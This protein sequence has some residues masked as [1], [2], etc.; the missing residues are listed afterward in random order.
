[1]LETF[2]NNKWRLMLPKHRHDF[3]TDNEWEPERIEALTRNI[4]KEDVVVDVGAEEGDMTAM[5]AKLAHGIH[6][7]EA[8]PG[9]WPNIKAIFK[10]N[11]IH[12]PLGYF[13][14]FASDEVLLSPENLN[15]VDK[16]DDGWPLC[17]NGEIRIGT[18]FRHLS[19][20]FDATKQVTLD[21]YFRYESHYRPTVINIDAEGSE[22]RVLKGAKGILTND[23]PLV[24]V[25]IHPEFIKE[26]YGHTMDDVLDYMTGLGYFHTLLA[27]D[28]EYHVAFHHPEGKRY[29]A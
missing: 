8:S 9:F 10:A 18:G 12:A 11:N 20:E 6:I 16:A 25:S 21:L 23:K 19:Q 26:M 29:I 24:F 22:L 4:T 28:H 27:V 15:Y 7:I 2:I 13:V 17:A 3:L 14:G 1:M 5:M